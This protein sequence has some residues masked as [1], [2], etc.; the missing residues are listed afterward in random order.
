MR[1]HAACPRRGWLLLAV[2]LP[3]LCLAGCAARGSGGPATDRAVAAS[4][5]PVPPVATFTPVPTPAPPSP[6][7]F[8]VVPYGAPL[9]DTA[10]TGSSLAAGTPRLFGSAY[11]GQRFEVRAHFR[12]KRGKRWFQVDV[13]GG[14]GWYHVVWLE[15]DHTLVTS[16]YAPPQ[17]VVV[18]AGGSLYVTPGP[19]QDTGGHISAYPGQRFK[20]RAH[21]RDR[22]GQIW[23]Q[24][25][26][27]LDAHG[28]DQRWL[29]ATR[30]V[31]A[32]YVYGDH[33]PT[34]QGEL[35]PGGQFRLQRTGPTVTAHITV[36]PVPAA[37][38]TYLFT[39]P[40]G[41]RP[42]QTVT[43]PGSSGRRALHIA[44][45][46]TVSYRDTASPTDGPAGPFTATLAWPGPGADPAVCAR[47][48]GVQKA[49]LAALQ[50][51]MG[52]VLP[53]EAVTWDHLARIRDMDAVIVGHPSQLA[54]LTG[55]RR[56][57]LHF[58]SGVGF[59]EILAQTP[60]LRELHLG[61]P[62]ATSLLR[63]CWRHCRNC[64]S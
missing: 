46:G 14:P 27:D 44:P 28:T 57:E 39:V 20:V 17:F 47:P 49:L 64:G 37:R 32:D 31:D 33:I 45:D 50:A 1:I 10:T 18:P 52:R 30:T 24:V 35:G 13:A 54:G 19:G 62:D 8:V 26:V 48:P 43:W 42:A 55:L 53:C 58:G 36:P 60:Q 34:V 40:P 22:T 21:A 29:E 61:L 63:I 23:F 51:Q 3:C 4:P 25:D 6:P 7:R 5:S 16:S 59:P 56:A 15:A 9:Y 12:D 38:D 41:W 11:P 2:L